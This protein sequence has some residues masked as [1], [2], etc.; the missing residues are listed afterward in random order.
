MSL[1]FPSR[2][3]HIT[4]GLTAVKYPGRTNRGLPE[5]KSMDACMIMPVGTARSAV[6]TPKGLPLTGSR[7]EL[8]L[9]PAQ[10]ETF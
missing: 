5:M 8:D 9:R 6:L 1:L 4:P 2:S 7:F 3:S 10:L